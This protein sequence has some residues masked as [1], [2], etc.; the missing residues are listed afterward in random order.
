MDYIVANYLELIA[1]AAGIAGVYLTTKQIIWC[2]PVSVVNVVL[3]AIVFYQSKL[4]QDALL[5]VFYFV[6]AVYGFYFWMKGGENH[7]EAIVQ[8]INKTLLIF[9]IIVGII[10]NF[11][12][13]YLFNRYTDA[14]LPYWDAASFTWGVIG[15]FLMARKILEN[16]IVWIIIDL[17]C[18]GIFFYKELYGFTV[19]Y[20]VF[21]ILAIYGYNNWRNSMIKQVLI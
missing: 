14:A 8:K 15:T 12:L 4:Y 2:W 10:S 9:I 21:T 16:W 19:L 17:I 5:Q 3:S 1:V 18:C 13:G 11:I 20:F 7:Q 6:M